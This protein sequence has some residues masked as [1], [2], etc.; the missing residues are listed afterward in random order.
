MRKIKDV[1]LTKKEINI[2]FLIECDGNSY[3]GFSVCVIEDG[4]IWAKTP[5]HIT[6]LP[7]DKSQRISVTRLARKAVRQ[8][9][10]E[11]VFSLYPKNAK[12]YRMYSIGQLTNE[13][14]S[15]LNAP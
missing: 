10:I 7:I 14:K 9:I 4:C 8:I 3:S 12:F 5:Y 13:H 2:L 11:K 15:A 6:P 1:V